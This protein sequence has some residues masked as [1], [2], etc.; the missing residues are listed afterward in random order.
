MN[1][2]EMIRGLQIVANVQELDYLILIIKRHPTFCNL[3][4]IDSYTN[5]DS[6]AEALVDWAQENGKLDELGLWV[7]KIANVGK[8]KTY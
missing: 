2:G 6:L 7:E 5:A 1:A 3:P 8:I 4:K